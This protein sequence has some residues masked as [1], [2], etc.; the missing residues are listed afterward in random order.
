M[1]VAFVGRL[2]PAGIFFAS[3]LMALLYMGGEQ[4]Q[5]YL[6]LPYSISKVFQGMLLFFL[7]G[8]DVFINFRVRLLRR[9]KK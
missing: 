4:A 9:I 2:S 1:I 8:S 7:L 5:Q 3:L 6:N